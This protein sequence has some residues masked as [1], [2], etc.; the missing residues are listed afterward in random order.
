MMS[1]WYH[2]HLY[3]CEIK[4]FQYK[5]AMY[6]RRCW[7]VS[8]R[9]MIHPELWVLI[10]GPASLEARTSQETKLR[11]LQSLTLASNL[12]NAITFC[13]CW[14]ISD[15]LQRSFFNSMYSSLLNSHH[16]HHQWCF[17]S[18]HLIIFFHWNWMDLC[19]YMDQNNNGR[20]VENEITWCFVCL[21]STTFD[22]EV[23]FLVT[24]KSIWNEHHSDMTLVFALFSYSTGKNYN[25]VIYQIFLVS[26][27]FSLCT[28]YINFSFLTFYIHFKISPDLGNSWF[29]SDDHILFNI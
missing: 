10:V 19:K 22:V 23:V 8:A 9:L 17:F 3:I 26:N 16:H 12:S 7:K 1:A 11:T 15:N 27:A 24:M 21:L 20:N 18:L 13:F 5:I 14:Q 2:Y 4:Y 25:G 28:Y 29:L 6:T